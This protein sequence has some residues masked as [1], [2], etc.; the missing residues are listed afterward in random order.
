[1]KVNVTCS[2]AD[3]K[4]RG[5]VKIN[6]KTFAID[7]LIP[8]E[9]ATIEITKQHTK[10]ISINK[11]SVYRQKP[12]CEYYYKCG[13]CQLQ[14]LNNEGQKKFKQ[15]KVE[16]LLSG[17]APVNPIISMDYPFYYR[18]KSHFT[19][20]K[21]R[22]RKIIA[23][24]Y[25]ENSHRIVDLDRCIIQD[26]TTNKINATIKSMLVSFKLE[27]YNEDTK[28]GFLRHVLIR[29][30]FTSKQVMVVLVTASSMFPSKNNFIKALLKKHPEIT[31]IVQNINDRKTSMVLGQK[32][33][34]LFGKG[35][36]VDELN[37]FKFKISPSSFFQINPTQTEKL[38]QVAINAADLQ[39]DDVVLDAYCG[40]GT[41]GIFA[42]NYVKS[43][44]GVELNKDAIRDAITNAK[45]NNVKNI[46]FEN[47]DASDFMVQLVNDKVKIDVVILDPPRSG[48]DER[49]IRA[50]SM[51]NPKKIVYVSCNPQTQ[52]R[53]LLLFEKNGY[54]VQ[55]IQPVDMFAHTYHVET[56]VLM[57]RVEK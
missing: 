31:T 43:V 3:D 10:L 53:D 50:L 27:P 42:S 29:T 8:D 14:H 21:N 11:P 48:S 34:V 33:V 17:F 18:N 4:G 56:I 16:E 25:E 40:T 26:D 30:G 13:G 19:F 38:Y 15:E 2:K 20:Q 46:W 45:L 54:K 12:P 24:M 52:A 9:E 28:T 22:N 51:L 37:G 55:S 39:K 44:I 23:G 36:I 32:E 5:I 1:M 7:Y 41:I 35:F 47:A 6:N 49:F 57:S